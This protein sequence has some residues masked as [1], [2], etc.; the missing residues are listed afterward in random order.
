LQD[1]AI[2]LVNHWHDELA[3]SPTRWHVKGHSSEQAATRLHELQGS[4]SSRVYNLWPDAP[5]DERDALRP[6]L[7]SLTSSDG[8]QR[9]ISEMDAAQ[10][11]EDDFLYNVDAAQ[12]VTELEAVH[13]RRNVA[14]LITELD[15]LPRRHAGSFSRNDDLELICK[16]QRVHLSQGREKQ[17]DIVVGDHAPDDGCKH[18]IHELRGHAQ[19]TMGLSHELVCEF[20]PTYGSSRAIDAELAGRVSEAMLNTS[21]EPGRSSSSAGQSLAV[22]RLRRELEMEEGGQHK[23]ARLPCAIRRACELHPELK[24]A[25][26]ALLCNVALPPLPLSYDTDVIQYYIAS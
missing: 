19:N 17:K 22:R 24:A 15:D 14:N 11:A 20:L 7:K 6:M 26:P 9:L 10:A 1:D 3:G 13:D 18:R 23:K 4:L 21:R 2:L 12:W 8:R 16:L 5:A 25:H